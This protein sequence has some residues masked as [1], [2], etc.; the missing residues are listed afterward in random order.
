[1]KI[2]KYEITGGPNWQ[3]YVVTALF[4]YLSIAEAS[5][6]WILGWLAFNI[7]LIPLCLWIHQ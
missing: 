3:W 5:P 6:W 4:L 2:G 1:M 7:V